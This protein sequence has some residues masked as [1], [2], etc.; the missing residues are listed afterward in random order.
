MCNLE[1]LYAFSM[2]RLRERPIWIYIAQILAENSNFSE[3]IEKIPIIQIHVCK[4]SGKVS[5]VFNE[6]FERTV[7]LNVHFQNLTK[8]SKFPEKIEKFQYFKYMYVSNLGKIHS[9]P[10]SNLRE[11][12]IWILTCKF[13]PK[14]QSFNLFWNNSI[15]S[16]SYASGPFMYPCTHLASALTRTR[17]DA[18]VRVWS[19]SRDMWRYIYMYVPDIWGAMFARRPH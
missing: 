3:K 7:D 13:C 5:F 2:S 1:K 9:V 19:A 8:N 16:V 15:N 10:T 12:S 17:S 14:I 11:R 6:S 18:H 4:Q